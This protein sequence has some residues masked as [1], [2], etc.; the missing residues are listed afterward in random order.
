MA[1]TQG[2]E[3]HVAPGHFVSETTRGQELLGH[4]L[5]HVMQQRKGRVRATTETRGVVLPRVFV[6]PDAS[7]YIRTHA[8]GVAYA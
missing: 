6:H 2:N 8:V 3:I 4:E 5:G 7:S 1:Y